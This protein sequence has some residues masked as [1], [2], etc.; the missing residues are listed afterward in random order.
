LLKP[1]RPAA[2]KRLKMNNDEAKK[3]LALYR[4]GTDDRTEPSFAEALKLVKPNPTPGGQEKTDPELSRWFQEHCSSYLHTRAS[5]LKIPVPPALQDRILDRYK[6]P[7]ASIIPFRPMVILSAAAVL[8]LCLTLTALFWRSHGREDDFNTYRN[9]MARTALRPYS[10][11]LQSRDLRSINAYLAGRKAPSDNAVP[12][13]MS[14]AQPVGCAVL[15]WQG[16][17]VSMI[18]FRSGQPLAAG[19]QTDLWLFVVNQSAVRN[20]PATPSPII[21]RIKKLTTATWTKDGKM[22][23]LAGTGDEQFLRRYF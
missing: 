14:K 11:D 23:V 9:R 20:R 2:L 7:T 6:P 15:Q 3:I 1:L 21:A 16:Q 19:E 12:D 5:L 17:P 18:C 22:Y 13:G 8:V 10:M 4:P